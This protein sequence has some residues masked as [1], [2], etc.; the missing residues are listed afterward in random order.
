MPHKENVSMSRI[1][2]SVAVFLLISR[3]TIA[4]T[5]TAPRQDLEVV[6]IDEINTEGSEF[7]PWISEDGR[8]L[9]WAVAG[10][11][12]DRWV[13][14]TA[15]RESPNSL[16]RGKQKLFRGHSPVVSNDGMEMLFC[17]SDSPQFFVATRSDLEKEFERPKPIR[18]LS[19]DDNDFPAPRCLSKD[20]LTL[21]F[22]V[23]SPT[24][25]AWDIWVSERENRNSPWQPPKR[26]DISVRGNLRFSQPFVTEDHLRMFVTV[27]DKSDPQT[28]H[29][30]ILEREGQKEP[31]SRLRYPDIRDVDGALPNCLTPR[32][33]SKTKELVL[34]S[35]K[36]FRSE[37]KMKERKFDLWMVKDFVIPE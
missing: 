11:G 19:F 31:F 12:V 6:N 2:A 17:S 33:V 25:G 9:Y 10:S 24:E 5:T 29:I 35:Q 3:A 26:A 30:G 34:V 7:H 20:A 16:F 28:V 15:K 14:W 23:K 27:V 1:T 32:Y 18:E 8:T 22:E 37:E 4:Q 36:L 13:I 21:Y